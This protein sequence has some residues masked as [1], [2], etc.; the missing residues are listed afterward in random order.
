MFEMNKSDWYRFQYERYK[1]QIFVLQQRPHS[2]RNELMIDV[3]KCKRD[4]YYRLL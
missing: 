4:Y 2:R 1:Q 3:A